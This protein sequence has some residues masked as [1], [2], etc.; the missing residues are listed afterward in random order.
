[1]RGGERNQFRA[2][3]R[4]ANGGS[5]LSCSSLIKMIY[6]RTHGLFCSA[7][8][9]GSSSQQPLLHTQPVGNYLMG[10]VEE[11]HQ[12]SATHF[13][14]TLPCGRPRWVR[15]EGPWTSGVLGVGPL[16]AITGSAKRWSPSG[17]SPLSL[18]S[19]DREG[20]LPGAA[21]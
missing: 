9:L 10:F 13:P 20:R 19:P 16:A 17:H 14:C 3:I 8:S 21:G 12:T 6:N 5:G 2:I 11:H 15:A 4:K 1:M 7:C 18:P